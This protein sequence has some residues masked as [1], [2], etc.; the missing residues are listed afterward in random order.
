MKDKLIELLEKC[1]TLE[2]ILSEKRAE[3]AEF[4]KEKKVNY[5][6]GYW[7][8]RV[9]ENILREKQAELAELEKEKDV[10]YPPGYWKPEEGEMYHTF[11]DDR[12][13]WRND[14]A[15]RYNL[16][17]GRVFKTT[18]EV[19]KTNPQQ[20]AYSELIR[21][22]AEVN[23]KNGQWKPDWKNRNQ[24]KCC[25][26]YSWAFLKVDYGRSCVIQAQHN[27]LYFAEKSYQ[28]IRDRLGEKT[29]KLALGIEDDR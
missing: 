11:D 5:P 29:I 14:S 18:E 23:H 15:D 10:V 3:L 7:P 2:S 20:A 21:T 8:Y 16:N 9:L 12:Y 6:P 1:S 17:T 24:G 13:H 4:E 27:R 25:L 26:I 22:I 19:E 28:K